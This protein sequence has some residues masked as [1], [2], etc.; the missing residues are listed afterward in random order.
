MTYF[1]RSS[2][3]S[4]PLWPFY[5][6]ISFGLEFLLQHTV[7]NSALVIIHFSHI[8]MSIK[9][10][11]YL[12][13]RQFGVKLFGNLALTHS[14]VWRY[15]VSYTLAYQPEEVYDVVGPVCESSDVFAF[16]L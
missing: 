6:D 2:S 11:N 4:I 3:L 15:K 7:Q 16:L 1:F 13:F 10:I 5:K 8:L 14:V 12:N 9:L